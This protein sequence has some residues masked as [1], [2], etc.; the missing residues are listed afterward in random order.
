MVL[1]YWNYENVNYLPNFCIDIFVL[2]LCILYIS[3]KQLKSI[4]ILNISY[5][6]W[7]IFCSVISQEV[8]E[9][10][11]KESDMQKTLEYYQLEAIKKRHI[12]R[13]AIEDKKNLVR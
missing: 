5:F 7:K 11:K 8:Q 13:A 9:L 4:N 1:I 12:L 10:L 6:N 2:T 3:W